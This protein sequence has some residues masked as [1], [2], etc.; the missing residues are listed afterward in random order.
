MA[1]ELCVLQEGGS[2]ETLFSL[3]TPP[4]Q[5]LF[6]AAHLSLDS[7]YRA[8]AGERRRSLSKALILKGER[9]L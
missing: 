6:P 5:G 8:R 2:M 7:L 9:W 3:Q 1:S 4:Y